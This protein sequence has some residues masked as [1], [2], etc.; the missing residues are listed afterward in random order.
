MGNEPPTKSAPSSAPSDRI[1]TPW[2]EARNERNQADGAN[3]DKAP[4]GGE[5]R[6]SVDGRASIESNRSSIDVEKRN[7]HQLSVCKNGDWF[8][9]GY[10]NDKKSGLGV[11]RFHNGDRFDGEFRRDEISG[12]GCYVFNSAGRYEGKWANGAYHGHGVEIWAR[13]STYRGEYKGGM[14]CGY[15]MCRYFQGDLYQGLWSNGKRS[16]MG[17]QQCA[18]DSQYIGDYAMGMKQGIGVYI[19]RNGDQY[20]GEYMEDAPHGHGVYVHASGGQTYYG[21]W[22]KGRKHGCGTLLVKGEGAGAPSMLYAVEFENGQLVSS[23]PLSVSLAPLNTEMRLERSPS[24]VDDEAW[25]GGWLAAQDTAA[26]IAKR[27]EAVATSHFAPNSEAQMGIAKAIELADSAAK[28]ARAAVEL[29]RQRVALAP[30]AI[31]GFHEQIGPTE[32]GPTEEEPTVQETGIPVANKPLRTSS[33]TYGQRIGQRL[34]KTFFPRQ[35]PQDGADSMQLSPSEVDRSKFRTAATFGGIAADAIPKAIHS[36]KMSGK[37]I[38]IENDNASALKPVIGH[39][40]SS[41][42]FEARAL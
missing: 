30:H 19:F 28:R 41:K 13:G 2:E 29:A 32:E 27:A 16:G 14:R 7:G 18:D 20:K 5:G 10:H 34:V 11:Y 37:S 36:P 22:R 21:Q 6:A 17:M 9:G 38:V 31:F 35:E 39:A 1:P 26:D 40:P 42:S 8:E 3:E 33:F 4:N 12:H 24:S 25:A 15:G 23:Q